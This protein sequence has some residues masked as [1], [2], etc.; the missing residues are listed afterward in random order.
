M[1]FPTCLL[2]SGR[3]TSFCLRA[4]ELANFQSRLLIR[5][6]VGQGPTMLAVGAG[7]GLLG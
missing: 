2:I 6:I 5:I 7:R 3:V 4:M 1:S